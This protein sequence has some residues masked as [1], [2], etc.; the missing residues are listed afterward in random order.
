[1]RAFPDLAMDSYICALLYNG[2]CRISVPI[3]FMISGALI[4]EQPTDFRK[5]TARTLSLFVKTIIWI[6]V[7]FVWDYLY[8]GDVYDFAL[9]FTVPIR[10]HFWFLYALLGIYI[11]IPF[12]QKLVSGESKKLLGYFSILFIAILAIKFILNTQKMQVT[13]EI[14]LIESSVYAGYFIMGYVLRHYANQIKVKRWMCALVFLAGGTATTLLTLFASIKKNAHVEVFCDFRSFF[15]AVSAL[16]VFLFVMKT[17]DFRHRPW[18]SL[19]SK[20]S[21]NIYMIHVFFLDIIQENIDITN[22]SAWIG[23]PIFFV[24]LFSMSFIFSFILGKLTHDHI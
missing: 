20:Y 9:I 8:L 2:L 10:V 17:E 5:N 7:F 14:P 22:I 3:F 4:L 6:A 15:I 11:T 12:W 19:I 18:L 24:F 13:Y 16:A 21:F 23:F 1:M